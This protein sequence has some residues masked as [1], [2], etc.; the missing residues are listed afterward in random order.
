[1]EDNIFVV[2]IEN[3]CSE[4]NDTD[5]YRRH[6]QLRFND[7]FQVRYLEGNENHRVTVL[8]IIAGRKF[9]SIIMK[10]LQVILVLLSVSVAVLYASVLRRQATVD[11][12]DSLEAIR[13]NYGCDAVINSCGKKGKCCDVHDACYKQHGCTMI[14]WIYLCKFTF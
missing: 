8:W 13:D 3:I 11:I 7:C 2:R 4:V 10:S 5:K 14:S 1:M 12:V 6:C 9:Q